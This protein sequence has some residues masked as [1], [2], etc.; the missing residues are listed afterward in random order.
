MDQAQ[1]K[2][3]LQVL[4]V[5]IPYF[6]WCTYLVEARPEHYVMYIAVVTCY[7]AT[8]KTRIWVYNFAGLIMYWVVYDSLRIC[9]NY[10][11]NPVHISEPYLF[12][13]QWF[14]ITTE[15][16]RQ[17]L[18]EFFAT[19]TTTALDITT[20]L[21][22]LSWLPVP[23][24]FGTWLIFRDKILFRQFMYGFLCTNL[25]GFVL[26][27]LYPAAPPWYVELNGFVF[28]PDTGRSAAGLERFDQLIGKPF[29]HNMYQRNSNVFAAIPSLHSAYPLITLFYARQVP[30]RWPTVLFVFLSLG[31][32]FSAVYLR[33][34]YVIDVILGALTAVAGYILARWVFRLIQPNQQ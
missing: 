28:N 34:H 6:L 22:Y 7:L 17:T 13:K 31:I 30:Q 8:E 11:I 10:K 15:A 16:G 12:D 4:L 19:R 2:R 33:H 1:Q 21:F 23:I 27:Y 32:W 3:L 25:I 14:G 5:S 20:A 29:F 24:L 26:Y 18:N 9:P